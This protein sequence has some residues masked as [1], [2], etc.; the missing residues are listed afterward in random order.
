[1]TFFQLS[2]KLYKS[3]GKFSRADEIFRNS[4]FVRLQ[5]SAELHLLTFTNIYQRAIKLTLRTALHFNDAKGRT[6]QA[7]H[8]LR[9]MIWGI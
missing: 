7:F 6:G 3:K 2:E 5:N 9:I 8:V 4:Y 1:V